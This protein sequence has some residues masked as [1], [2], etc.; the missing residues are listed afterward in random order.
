MFKFILEVSEDF[1]LESA[2][3]PFIDPIKIHGKSGEEVINLK[4]RS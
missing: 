2:D 4:D 3:K 1:I